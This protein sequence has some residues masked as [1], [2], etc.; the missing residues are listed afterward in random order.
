[1]RVLLG[2]DFGL[3]RVG[4]ALARGELAEPWKVVE[5]KKAVGEIARGAD[6]EGIEA[7]VVG[8]SEGA[9]A[10]ATREF[11]RDI[12]KKVGLPVFFQDETLSSQEM[13]EKLRQLPLKK[14]RGAID[15]Y[16]A[17]AV[18]QDFIDSRSSSRPT[19]VS[20]STLDE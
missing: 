7:I 13:K 9:M 8:L 3:K 18:L 10:R 1:M 2:V 5:L 14:R 11:A 4:L 19:G 12:N 16:V 15:H 6:R 20:H 17:A